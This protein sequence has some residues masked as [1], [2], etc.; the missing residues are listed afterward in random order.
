MMPSHHLKASLQS[1]ISLFLKADGQAV[2]R[3]SEHKS[4]SAVSRFL[5]HYSWELRPVIRAMRQESLAQIWQYYPK[6]RGRRPTLNVI[7][8]LTSIEKT[9]SF[10]HLPIAELDGVRGLHLVVVFLFIG[11]L[12][13]PWGLR[14]WRGKG[15][16]TPCE[17]ALKLLRSLA[18]SLT[19]GFHIRVLADAG[20]SSSAF[21]SKLKA[22]GFEAVTGM[23]SD[24]KLQDGRKLR[25]VNKGEKVMLKGL[26]F[27]VWIAWFDIKR[28]QRT[29]RYFII[30][31]TKATAR[32]IKRWGR[33]RWRIEAFFKTMKQRF[34]LIR[35]GQS[36]KV[37]VYRYIALSLLAYLLTQL[38]VLEL[39]PDG[40]PD[41][42]AMARSLDT[43]LFPELRLQALFLKLEHLKPFLNGSLVFSYHG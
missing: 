16:D 40:W 7:V 33:F 11:E 38:R 35:F 13:L 31:L 15:T 41:W 32:T 34:S 30:S 25:E 6:K 9:G 24:R 27:P 19:E 43:F 39:Q 20:F 26:S 5:N 10:E 18:P 29:C 23:R 8:D 21:L 2:I 42:K 36:S 12:R 14:I 1:L 3:R 22:L 4:A 28:K 37:G 17:L